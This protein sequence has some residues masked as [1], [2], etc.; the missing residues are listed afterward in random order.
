MSVLCCTLTALLYRALSKALA[1]RLRVTTR[2]FEH[3][4]YLDYVLRHYALHLHDPYVLR[5]GFP[6]EVVEP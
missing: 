3:D 5:P 1:D 4:Q 6:V 2:L